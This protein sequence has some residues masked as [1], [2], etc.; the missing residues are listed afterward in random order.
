[1][2]R[3][4]SISFAAAML[5]SGAA[6][7]AQDSP[8]PVSPNE[9]GV[10]ERE[11]YYAPGTTASGTSTTHRTSVPTKVY[12]FP[13]ETDEWYASGAE[14][15]VA[16]GNRSVVDAPRRPHAHSHGESSTGAAC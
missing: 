11:P 7:A 5:I 12:A 14:G 1:M 13:R 10:H 9:H 8:F 16:S 2:S 3:K 15:E 6:L 4:I